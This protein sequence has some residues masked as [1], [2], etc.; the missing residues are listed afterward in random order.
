MEKIAPQSFAEMLSE[1]DEGQIDRIYS[2]AFAE[3]KG[4]LEAKA[5][6]HKNPWKGEIAFSA[7]VSVEPN[8]K[9][10]WTFARPKTKREEEKMPKAIMYLDPDT[11]HMSNGPQVTIKGSLDQRPIKSAKAPKQAE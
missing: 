2:E 6:F 4:Y 9:V 5:Y 7:K 3:L 1:A 8:G 10:E 11:G